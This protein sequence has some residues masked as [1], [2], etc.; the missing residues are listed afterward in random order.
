MGV[1]KRG[2]VY[3]YR[4][5]WNNETVREST[6]QGNAKV[7]RQMEAAHRTSLAKGEVGIRDRK[8]APTLKEFCEK[9]FM[10]WAKAS[11]EETSPNNYSWFRT[12]IKQLTGF[13][14]LAKLH[15]DEITNETVAGYAAHES[16]RVQ[17]RGNGT[18]TGLAVSSINS[19]IRVLRRVLSLAVEWGVIE[20]SP[21][22]QLLTG[23]K[24]RERVITRD[25][26]GAYLKAASPLLRDLTTVLA[27]TGTR[28]DE[29]YNLRW[30]H[31]GWDNGRFGTVLIP[32]GKTAA[33]RRVLP[34]TPRVRE[35]LQA[36]WE[37]ARRP[38]E[39]WAFP[40]PTK[41]GHINQATVKK[42]HYAALKKANE[43]AD[44]KPLEKPVVRPFVLYDFR[45]TFLT[46]LG[47]SGCDAWTLARI[48]GH[49]S[50]TISSRYVHPSE[51]AVLNAMSRMSLHEVQQTAEQAEQA[52]ELAAIQTINALPASI[53]A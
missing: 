29:A 47:E 4:F 9:R 40:A 3:W 33:A 11:F 16:S 43:D 5:Q 49:S 51:N 38:A 26:E 6:K 36:R 19:S 24:K 10:P 8:P 14:G 46:R 18:K 50:I 37:R 17:T 2:D 27:D 39:G 23:E 48:A 15:L 41:A 13:E 34:L 12:G 31:V 25:E 53:P 44:G 45:H 30:E 32:N 20:S 52:L 21:K 28:P 1:Y 22:I 35:V 7:A 42:T